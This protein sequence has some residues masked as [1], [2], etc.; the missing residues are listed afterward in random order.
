[1]KK[2]FD[3]KKDVV[4]MRGIGVSSGIVIGKAHVIA[5]VEADVLLGDAVPVCHLDTDGVDTEVHRFREALKVSR[6]QLRKIKR[7]LAKEERVK[8]HIGIVD[9]HL[10]ILNDQMLIND[11]IS[12]IKKQ[13]INAEW[14][15]KAVMKGIKELF[16]GIDDQ[17]FKERS[18][19]VEH[20]VD[21]IL[22]NLSGGNNEKIE[23]VTEPSI[24]VAHD[25]SPTDTAQMG[26]G[27]VLAFLTDIGGRTSH[28]AIMARSLELPAV[29]GLENVTRSVATGDTVI[30]DGMTGAVIINPSDSVID[31][32]EKRRQ[33][34]KKYGRALRHYRSLPSETTDGHRVKLLGNME[35]ISEVT[36]LLDHGSEGVGLYRSEFLFLNRKTLPTEDEHVA[37]YKHVAMKMSPHPV[38]VRT[39]DVGGDKLLAAVDNIEEINP[40][41]GL[42]AIRF[43]LKR[44]D[45]FKVQLRGILRAS[46]FGKIKILFPMISGVEELRRA[47]ALLEEAKVELTDEGIGFDA[48]IEVGVMI[49]VPSAALVADLLAKEVDFFS[50]GT[51][52]LLQYTLAIDRVNE[53]VAYLYEPF[54]PAVLRIIK[55]VADI[56]IKEG[57]SISVCGEMAGEPEH[58]LVFIGMGIDNLSM[59]AFSLLRV[60]KLVRSVSYTEAQEISKGALGFSTAREVEHY[61]SS[62]L[63]AFYKEEYWS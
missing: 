15:L 23:D 43:S 52:D 42:R 13:R 41:L 44:T 50:I 3:N 14:A 29:V 24:V 18:S 60:K 31:V 16:D 26:K 46:A 32:Y 45:I 19:D 54:H 11:T 38:V 5:S 63:S 30:V 33:R 40:A 55:H 6:E 56:A 27:N 58:A 25:L 12:I 49:E 9:A 7:K 17:Y 35:L 36:T 59:N 39:L 4:L 48:T 53:H 1:M 10:M 22:V 47:K 2:T 21:R 62:R 61:V 57:I 28:T 20:I 34:Y 8:E 51:N 37:A